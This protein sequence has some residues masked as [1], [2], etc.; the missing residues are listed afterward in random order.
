MVAIISK[1]IG[2]SFARAVFLMA[3]LALISLLAAACASQGEI[4]VGEKAPDFTLASSDG[5]SVSLSDYTGEHPVLLFFHMAM[6]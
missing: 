4:A 2:G 1:I 6:G 3:L 5:V